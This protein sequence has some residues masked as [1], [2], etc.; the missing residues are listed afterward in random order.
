MK[1]IS[2]D[3][4]SLMDSSMP[5]NYARSQSPISMLT[6][7]GTLWFVMLILFAVL[8]YNFYYLYKKKKSGGDVAKSIIWVNA[9]SALGAVALAGAL[10]YANMIEVTRWSNMMMTT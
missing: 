8:A 1:M 7:K 5:Y 9:V 4:A 2:N 10:Y 6:E 3:G